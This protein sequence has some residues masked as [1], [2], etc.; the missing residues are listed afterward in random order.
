VTAKVPIVNPDVDIP[1][2]PTK[3]Q[4]LKKWG[5]EFVESAAKKLGKWLPLAGAAISMTDVAQ[6]APQDRPH[7]VAKAIGG[8]LLPG[9]WGA[10]SEGF[11]GWLVPPGTKGPTGWVDLSPVP[12]SPAEKEAP[13][14]DLDPVPGSVADVERK[15]PTGWDDLPPVPGGPA[16]F[17]QSGG[18]IDL[19]PDKSI[20]DALGPRPDNVA[21]S[22]T[23]GGLD[24]ATRNRARTAAADADAYGRAQD[25]DE[26]LTQDEQRRRAAGRR[27]G[28]RGSGSGGQHGGGDVDWIGIIN[29]AIEQSQQHD[30]GQNHHP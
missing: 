8:E 28:N 11:A 7:E 5:G 16:D 9:P 2:P 14:I 23:D 12:G 25:A 21:A 6:A 27:P 18:W 13:W 30:Q 4:K 24:D 19:P 15:Q 3:W 26:Q 22:P 1:T 10:V 20:E 17:A 29:Q